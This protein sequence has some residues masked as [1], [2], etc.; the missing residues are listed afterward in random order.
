MARPISKWNSPRGFSATA[1]YMALTLDS[2]SLGSKLTAVVIVSLLGRW[3]AC[4]RSAADAEGQQVLA[5]HADAEFGREAIVEGDEVAAQLGAT[6][7][8]EAGRQRLG[9]PISGRERLPGRLAIGLAIERGASLEPQIES[10]SEQ[11][12]D[13]L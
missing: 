11:L 3:S 4:R 8:V 9:G 5:W 13:A 10:R 6:R 7:F 1:R 2:R 12:A